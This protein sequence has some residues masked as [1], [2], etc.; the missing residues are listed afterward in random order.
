M[1]KFKID[2]NISQI[3]CDYLIDENKNITLMFPKKYKNTNIELLE[4]E[5]KVLDKLI[6]AFDCLWFDDTRINEMSN[7]NLELRDYIEE[8]I[9]KI[10]EVIAERCDLVKKEQK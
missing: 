7:Y 2:F 6:A 10:M 4:V 3:L 1:R 5:K 8:S 9:Y